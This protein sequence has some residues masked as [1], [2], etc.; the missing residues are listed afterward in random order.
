M[1]RFY[2]TTRDL[3]LYVGLFVSPFVLVF[4]VSVFYLVHGLAQRPA[5]DQAAF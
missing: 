3:H 2:L 4:S 5:P 1:R